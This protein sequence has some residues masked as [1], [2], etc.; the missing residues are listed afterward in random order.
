V[1]QDF[2][3]PTFIQRHRGRSAASRRV[4]CC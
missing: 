1:G 3:S 4:K 2:I